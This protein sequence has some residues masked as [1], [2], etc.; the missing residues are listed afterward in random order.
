MLSQ[1]TTAVTVDAESGQPAHKQRKRP[2]LEFP[3]TPSVTDVTREVHTASSVIHSE[4]LSN[5]L[6]APIPAMIRKILIG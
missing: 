4:A 1:S 5:G 6:N 3:H 2:R